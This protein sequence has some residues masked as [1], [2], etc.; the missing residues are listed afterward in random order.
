VLADH[1]WEF[2]QTEERQNEGLLRLSNQI[3]EFTQAIHQLA[4]QMPAADPTA[5]AAGSGGRD[6]PTG[7]AVDGAG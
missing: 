7:G 2:V 3:L 1:Q 4:V 5:H 6:E